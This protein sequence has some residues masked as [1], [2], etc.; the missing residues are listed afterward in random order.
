MRRDTFLKSMAAIAAAATL[1]LPALAASQLASPVS[2]A[3][4]MAV[5]LSE[6]THSSTVMITKPMETS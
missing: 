1:P 4:T 6:P 2:W 5:I 3:L